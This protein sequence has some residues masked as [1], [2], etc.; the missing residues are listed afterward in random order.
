VAIT[1][2]QFLQSAVDEITNYPTLTKRFQIGDPLITQGLAS[3]AAMLADVANQVEVTAGETYLKARDVT[4]LADA[5]VKGVL[6][7][8]RPCIAAITV[9]NGGTKLLK[10]LGGRVLRDQNGRMWRVTTGAQVA[11]GGTGTIVAR[12]VELRTVTHAVAQNQPFYP[13]ELAEPDIGYIAEVTVTGWEY[14]PE[15]C[16]VLDGDLVYHIQTDEN[17]VLSL[18]F[19]VTGLAGTQP[20]TGTKLNISIYDT[21]G[22]I[23]PSVGMAFYFEYTDATEKATMVL[24][25]VSQAGEAPMSVTTMREICSFPGIYSENAV[26][27]ANFDFLVRK[28]LGAVT[29]LNVW[30]E[31]KEESVRPA[32]VENMN[33]LFV[34]VLKNGV[35][36]SALQSE[37]RLIITT[38]DNSYRIKFVDAIEKA[39]PLKLTLYVPSTYD[40]A[41]TMQAVRALILEN[42]GRESDWAKRGEAKMLKK[43]IYDLLRKNIPALTQRVADIS[44]DMIGDDT[45]DLPEHFRYVTEESLEVVTETAN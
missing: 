28:K 39:V 38:A 6:P 19:G 10:I 31:L 11:A 26:Y 9:T 24:S 23:S 8:G 12:Q 25:D 35:T 13:V 44:V 43:D 20:A 30:N 22:E 2:D 21:E 5:S 1:K 4:V 33:K 14:A 3:M 41:A 34:S 37:I 40:S 29:F 16:N 17:Q 15:F 32:S 18:V 45:A 42:Y 27:R 7:F 36:P